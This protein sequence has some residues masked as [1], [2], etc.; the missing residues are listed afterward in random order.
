MA[1]R[2]ED[3]RAFVQVVE[4]QSI[5]GAADNMEVA[6]SAVSRRLKDLE[7]R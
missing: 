6:P 3:L 4:Q 5:S 2:F 7:E 1:D